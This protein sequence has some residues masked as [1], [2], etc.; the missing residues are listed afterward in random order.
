MEASVRK[1]PTQVPDLHVVEGDYWDTHAAACGRSPSSVEHLLTFESRQWLRDGLALTKDVF[2]RIRADEEKENLLVEIGADAKDKID[3]EFLAAGFSIEQVAMLRSDGATTYDATVLY[4]RGD[5]H[6]ER[7]LV[8]SHGFTAGYESLAGILGSKLTDHSLVLFNRPGVDREN[9]E[10][11]NWNHNPAI[12]F[13][14]AMAAQRQAVELA[15]ERGATEVVIG[16]HSHSG[17]ITVANLFSPK[18]WSPEVSE[19]LIGSVLFNSPSERDAT[20]NSVIGRLML[21]TYPA[22]RKAAV[23]PLGGPFESIAEATAQ[24]LASSVIVDRMIDDGSIQ[25]PRGQEIYLASKYRA[26][27]TDWRSLVFDLGALRAAPDRFQ[28]DQLLSMHH[29]IIEGRH[30]RLVMPPAGSRLKRLLSTKRETGRRNIVHSKFH[31]GHFTHASQ[32]DE[33]NQE[34][35]E[36]ML[37]IPGND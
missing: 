27:E 16:G 6:P 14:D 34:V 12:R 3:Q 26:H 22:L 24:N 21:P 4:R 20:R 18:L 13:L 30:D 33:V 23:S 5:R 32:P 35:H 9:A 1:T 17:Q 8:L 15:L 28:R 29:L 31:T 11:I 7:A 2:R 19:A 36:F 37:N 10:I 25:D